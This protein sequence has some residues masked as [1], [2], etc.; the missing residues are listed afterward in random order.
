MSRQAPGDFLSKAGKNSSDFSCLRAVFSRKRDARDLYNHQW[1]RNCLNLNLTNLPM[2]RRAVF[3]SR[4]QFRKSGTFLFVMSIL[5]ATTVYGQ[6][7]IRPSLAGQAS[8]DARQE[9]VSRIPYNLLLGPVRLRVGATVG[10]EYNDN[11]N[12]AETNEQ[13]DFIVTPNLTLDMIWPITQLNTLRLDLGVGYS[14]YF[15]NSPYAT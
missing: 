9:D 10:V 8:S 13:D 7:A 1:Y 4:D 11:V 6:D 15:D 14:C 12:Y 5:L 3:L 2:S